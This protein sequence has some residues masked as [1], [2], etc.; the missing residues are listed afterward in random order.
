[1]LLANKID[2]EEDRKVTKK[3]GQEIANEYGMPFYETSARNN[4]NLE[5]AFT[6]LVR[7]IQRDILD[8][9]KDNDI[10]SLK[11]KKLPKTEQI[12]EVERKETQGGYNIPKLQIMDENE[13][14]LK[15]LNK[16]LTSKVEFENT[17]IEIDGK[18]YKVQLWDSAGQEEYRSIGKTCYRG[19]HGIVLVYNICNRKTFENIRNWL[20]TIE[21]HAKENTCLMLLA[22]KIDLEEDREVTKKMGQEIANEYGMPFYETSAL[23]NINLEQAFTKLVRNIQRDILD[24]EKDN[25]IISLKE[26]KLPKTEQIIEEERK[27]TQGGCC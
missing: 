26:K 15:F 7:N 14:G 22:N 11:E 5:Q 10:I 8:L 17:K 1:M 21:E 18:K 6:K 13:T 9:E 2:R 27:E 19:S 4:I 23:K 24:L 12:I 20:V 16:Y 3:M 25:D